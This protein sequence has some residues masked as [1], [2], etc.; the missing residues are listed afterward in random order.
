MLNKDKILKLANT[1]MPFGKYQG[2]YLT[3]LPEEYL[4]WFADRGFPRGELGELMQLALVVKT[5]GLEAVL[6]PL[7]P[8]PD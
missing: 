3:D 4:L 8:E 2:R 1:A 6:H 7:R 5:N